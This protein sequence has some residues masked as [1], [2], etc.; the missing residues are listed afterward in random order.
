MRTVWPFR[1]FGLKVLSL[2]LGLLL[3]MIVSG[4]ETV[5]R[6]LRVPLELQQV[7]AGVELASEVPATVEVRVRGASGAL[8]RV[9]PGDAVAVLDLH[10][11]RSGR[12]L[13]PLTPDQVR[14]PFGV[15]VVQVTPSTIGMTF[16]HTASRQIPVAPATDGKPAPG[17]VAGPATADPKS[18]EVVGPE[19]AV[20]HATE[21]W[22]EPVSVAGAREPVKATVMLG[23]EDPSLR[24]RTAK[25]AIITVPIVPAPLERTLHNR[26]VHLRNLAPNL[27][28]RAIPAMVDIGLRG[29][30]ATLGQF[31][32]DD[33]AAYVDLA[34]LGA[35]EYSLTVKASS[36]KDAGITHIEPTLVQVLIA[37]GKK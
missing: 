27:E 36:D 34:G 15:E 18:V 7:P 12:L 29:S 5:E 8:S 33:I 32:P 23:L 20:T 13:F 3:W 2:V 16:E 24:L 30:R 1:H 21:V 37:S 14:L 26:P 9:A 6:A 10:S 19:S 25:S 4:E 22:T 11:A 35:G 31:D 28:A 17:Y